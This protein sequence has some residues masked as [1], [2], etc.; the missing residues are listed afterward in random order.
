[1]C[2][3]IEEEEEEGSMKGRRK[4]GKRK[5]IMM[6]ESAMNNSHH[7][8]CV[9]GGCA[10]ISAESRCVWKKFGNTGR[11]GISGRPIVIS[12]FLT[13]GH[14]LVF[15]I[16]RLHDENLSLCNQSTSYFGSQVVS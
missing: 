16:L 3:I 14:Y 10:S 8:Y 7:G 6:I 15:G 2:T 12:F 13:L 1:M 5:R 9:W 11:F 4:T